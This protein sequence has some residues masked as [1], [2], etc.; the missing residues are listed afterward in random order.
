MADDGLPDTADKQIDTAPR[1]DQKKPA[2]RAHSAQAETAPDAQEVI[3]SERMQDS[4][5]SVFVAKTTASRDAATDF[6]HIQDSD[7]G[8]AL[9]GA[10]LAHLADGGT[11]SAAGDGLPGG[12]V[13]RDAY[14]AR[15]AVESE[16]RGRSRPKKSAAARRKAAA[17]SK[18]RKSSKSAAKAPA[19]RTAK[20][21]AKPAAKTSTKRPAKKAAKGPAKRTAKRL[22]KPAARTSAKR[23][24][25]RKAK[26]ASAASSLRRPKAKTRA[27]TAKKAPARI[28]RGKAKTKAKVKAR[29]AQHGK[30]RG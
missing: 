15:A 17:P 3:A 16:A 5:R 29:G 20:R 25:K 4:I 7:D 19:K 1:P 14:L 27:V 22:A 11:A 9:R 8:V 6:S 21:S 13:L 30:R 23:P 26:A 2:A 28:A 12:N 24:A 18:R 10:Y